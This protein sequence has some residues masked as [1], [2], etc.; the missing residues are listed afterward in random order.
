M[1]IFVPADCDNISHI[2]DGKTV[3]DRLSP[4]R[5]CLAKDDNSA[6]LQDE[7]ASNIIL[8]N[9]LVIDYKRN[10]VTKNYSKIYSIN[11][12]YVIIA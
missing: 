3:L 8:S 11:F 4:R 7:N 6:E 2:A 1:S 5:L 10:R 9:Q 12:L